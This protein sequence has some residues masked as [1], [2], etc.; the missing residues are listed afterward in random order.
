[1]I[2]IGAGVAGLAATHALMQAGISVR[3]LEKERRVGEPW[4][5]RHND[6]HLNTHRS[7]SSLPGVNY[8]RGTP[9]FPDKSLV[10]DHLDLFSRRHGLPIEYGVRIEE[11]AFAGGH[12]TITTTM[13]TLTAAHVVI[14]TG[15]DSTPHIPQWKDMAD[16]GGRIIHSADFGDAGDYAHK[17]VMVVGA[18]NSGFDVLNHLAGIETSALWLSARHGPTLLP[19]RIFN[20]PVHLMSPIVARLPVGVADALLRTTQRIAFGDLTK[21]NL[22][23]ACTGGA[24]RLA[25]DYIAIASDDGAADAIKAGR[26][27]VVP[28]I[29]QF[30]GDGVILTNGER[31]RPDIVIAATGYRTGLER[32]VGKLGVL[33]A[34]GFPL[35][36]GAGH[37]PSL[38]GLWF[39]G[40]RPS[41]RGC[42]ANARLQARAIAAAI[43]AG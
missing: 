5:R 43:K 33:D 24:S 14:A 16:F 34:R 41:I 3:L 22:P 38:P 18:G 1:M 42:F 20:I 30:T 15:R 39:T 4:R 9:A 8:P 26:I 17:K 23:P 11:I 36:N 31:I 27:Q 35:F 28:R 10:V 19:K 6:L 29:G 37:S 12:W 13:G 25:R 40:M 32:M 21:F 7:L 2:V